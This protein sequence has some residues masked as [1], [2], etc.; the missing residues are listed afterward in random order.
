MPS[1]T[2]KDTYAIE[3]DHGGYTTLLQVH[4]GR[5]RATNLGQRVEVDYYAALKLLAD[6]KKADAKPMLEQ[7]IESDLMGFFE[8]RMARELL[9]TE[10]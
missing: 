7:V 9:D 2:I 4:V 1:M 3:F 5:K 10:F 8:Y 6:E